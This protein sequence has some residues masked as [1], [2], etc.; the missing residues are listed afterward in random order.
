MGKKNGLFFWTELGAEH[1]CLIQ[2]LI[3]TCKLHD[4]DPNVYLTD[5]LQRVS[6]QSSQ[7]GRRLNT[8]AKEIPVCR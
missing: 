2:S 7:R 3:C 6:Q 5:V 8:K 4:I 1:I